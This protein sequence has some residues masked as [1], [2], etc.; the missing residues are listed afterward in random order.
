MKF[1]RKPLL[2]DEDV[3]QTDDIITYGFLAQESLREYINIVNSK[4]VDFKSQHSK[5]GSGSGRGSS[6]RS[7]KTC[8]KCNKKGHIKKYC[9]S[10]VHGSS[11]NTTKKSINEPPKWVTRKPVDSDTKDL[12][13]ATMTHNN[14]K[15]KWCIS[16]N[17]GQGAWGFHWKDD[18]KEW[19][20][21]QAKN[22]LVQFSDSA[23]KALIYCSYPMATSEMISCCQDRKSVV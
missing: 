5:N 21:K 6:A 17:N 2:C 15:Y 19:K 23:T 9:R 1:V 7:Y 10:K 18:H 4:Q 13:T 8:H 11:V 22:K 20:E 16:C 14:K 3:V 12:I